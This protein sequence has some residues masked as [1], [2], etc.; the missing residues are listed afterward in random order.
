MGE[1]AERQDRGKEGVGEAL[2]ERRR[3]GRIEA[4]RDRELVEWVGRF[5]SVTAEVLALRFGVSEQQVKRAGQA[6]GNA[7]QLRLRR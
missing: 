3:R 6:V 1:G 2:R 5:R 4:Q 7:P